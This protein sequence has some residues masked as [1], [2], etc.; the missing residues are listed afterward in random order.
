MNEHSAG[1]IELP[2]TRNARELRYIFWLAPGFVGSLLAYYLYPPII[3]DSRFRSLWLVGLFVLALVLPWLWNIVRKRPSDDMAFP[4]AYVFSSLAYALIALV[5]LLNRGLDRFPP[6]EVR[7]TVIRKVAMVSEPNV[8]L[9]SLR[10]GP[11][12]P[13]RISPLTPP[14][15][16][17]RSS[18]KPSPWNCTRVSSACH[19]PATFRPNEDRLIGSWRD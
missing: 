14:Y 13:K 6:S 19:G 12:K 1:G 2:S 10:G 11:T 15:F 7:T 3:G 8:T 4:A 5:F 17:A 16:A 18:G 9:L